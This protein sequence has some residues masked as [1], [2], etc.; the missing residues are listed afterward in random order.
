MAETPHFAHLVALLFLGSGF[1]A[2][3]WAVSFL[4]AVLARK[5]LFARFAG[6]TAMAIVA[7]YAVVLLGVAVASPDRTLQVGGWKYFCEADCHIA[8]QVEGVQ[9]ASTIGPEGKPTTARGQFV[10]VR[11]RTW[12]DQRTLAP[13]RGNSPLAPGPRMVQVVDDAGLRY[14]P[15]EKAAKALGL[16]STSIN[17]P[18]RPGESYETSLVF[19]IPPE[20]IN[21]RPLIADAGPGSRLLIDHENSPLHGK[22]FLSLDGVP[23]TTTLSDP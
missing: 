10:I 23:S 22:I 2:I 8:Y 14:F 18:L 19:D 12:F 13:F 3:V 17:Q 9:S 1:L 5:Y 4:L 20:A 16:R 15:I 21:P 11:L 7:G 6:I